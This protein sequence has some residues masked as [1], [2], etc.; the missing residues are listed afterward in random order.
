MQS[1][2]HFFQ[3]AV[4]ALLI[5][6]LVTPG[7][8]QNENITLLGTLD[9]YTTYSNVWGHVDSQGNE[10]ALLGHESGTSIIDITDPTLPV[11]VAMI[12]GPTAS[13]LIWREIKVWQDYMYIVSEH[14]SPS[15]NSGVQIVDISNL[16]TTATLSTNYRWPNVTEFTARAHTVS[17]DD[18]GYLYVNGGSATSGTGGVSS[19]TRVFDLADPEN[20]AP[21]SFWN[22]VYVHDTQIRNNIAF[23]HNIFSGGQIQIYDVSDRANPGLIHTLTYPNGFSHQS[24]FTEDDNYMLTCNEQPGQPVNVWDISVLWD[25]DSSNDDLISQVA[26]IPVPAT[27]IAH[28]IYIKGNLGYISHYD[29]GVKVADLTD[30]TNPVIV[31][32]YDTSDAWGVHVFYPSNNFV[33]SDVN[34]GLYVFRF[35]LLTDIEE[36]TPVVEQFEL[37]QNYPNPFNPTTTI[38]YRLSASSAVTLT[39]FDMLGQEVNTLVKD[40]QSAGSHTVVWNA[41]DNNGRPVTSGMYVYKLQAGDFV[42]SKTMSLVR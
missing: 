23:A 9:E 2:H 16:P 32:N 20:P 5:I 22:T 33:V 27:S 18:Q 31:G 1:H 15:T 10:Y 7:W 11:E 21:V 6:F 39:V 12:P 14:T 3:L 29:L 42:Q 19:G 17:I 41:T 35:D 4:G 36:E 28:E 30:P 38:G 34:E 8:G 24:W 26:T 37:D 40:V 25:G 13:G